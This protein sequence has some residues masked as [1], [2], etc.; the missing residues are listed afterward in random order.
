MPQSGT[1]ILVSDISHLFALVGTIANDE[2]KRASLA[3]N[4]MKFVLSRHVSDGHEIA[5]VARRAIRG[6]QLYRS[7]VHQ[8]DAA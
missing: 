2:R 7:R 8:S 6:D 1:A 3:E 4:G 5:E